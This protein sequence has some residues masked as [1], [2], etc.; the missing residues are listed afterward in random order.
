MPINSTSYKIELRF[1]ITP[2]PGKGVCIQGSGVN[3]ILYFT[4]GDKN[5]CL[6]CMAGFPTFPQIH[7]KP[8]DS[9]SSLMVS[10]ISISL[11]RQTLRDGINDGINYPLNNIKRASKELEEGIKRSLDVKKVFTIDIPATLVSPNPNK[12]NLLGMLDFSTGIGDR[13]RISIDSEHFLLE[14]FGEKTDSPAL[15]FYVFDRPELKNGSLHTFVGGTHVFSSDYHS[16]VYHDR[17]EYPFYRF[18]ASGSHSVLIQRCDKCEAWER[19]LYE[20]LT[21]STHIENTEE[22]I[23]DVMV[24]I[25]KLNIYWMKDGRNKVILE[26]IKILKK[27]NTLRLSEVSKWTWRPQL[28][29]KTCRRKWRD[30]TVL[31]FLTAPRT[32]IGIVSALLG[33]A[34][35]SV[36]GWLFD[37]F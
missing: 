9:F 37:W 26:N 12:A 23:R 28:W 6:L 35:G 18:P 17:W 36:V 3:S 7:N 13:W 34:I 25:R 33:G 24:L 27:R 4:E 21:K 20:L 11:E 30:F 19:M 22:F 2:I 32:H 5:F 16:E 14:T 15:N 29:K 10:I 31:E 8:F 1:Y